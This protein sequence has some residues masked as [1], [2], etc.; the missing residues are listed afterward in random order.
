M[1]NVRGNFAEAVSYQEMRVAMRVFSGV[2]RSLK[3]TAIVLALV[4]TAAVFGS[5]VAKAENG[6]DRVSF[7]HR[8][9][10]ND[11]ETVGDVVCFLCSVEAHGK[12]HGDVVTFLGSVRTEAPVQGD[13][14]TFGGNVVLNEEA[15]V[16]GDLVIFGG[17]VRKSSGSHIGADQVIFPTVIFFI[18]VLILVGIL[19]ALLA[20]FRR[21]TPV[22]YIPPAR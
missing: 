22:Y 18:P 9:V 8:I 20:I 12:I 5:R 15:S 11:G 19:W 13:V 2:F 3:Q 14:V 17:D 1:C 10:V 4:L 21:R 16:G 6:D 7:G